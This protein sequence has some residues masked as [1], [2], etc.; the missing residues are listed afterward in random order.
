[1]RDECAHVVRNALLNLLFLVRQLEKEIA[2]L[3]DVFSNCERTCCDGVGNNF[4]KC[5]R[6]DSTPGA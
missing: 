4:G 6:R 2:A 3:N 1:M 5:S